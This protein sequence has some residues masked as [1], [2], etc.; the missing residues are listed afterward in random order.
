MECHNTGRCIYSGLVCDGY[1]DCGDW[2]D[3]RNCSEL[4]FYLLNWCSIVSILIRV[5]LYS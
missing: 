1:N 2:S 5:K 3:E 4:H